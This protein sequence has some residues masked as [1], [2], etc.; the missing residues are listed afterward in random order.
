VRATRVVISRARSLHRMCVQYVVGWRGTTAPVG[1]LKSVVAGSV[2]HVGVGFS[3]GV[4]GK[5]YW[6]VRLINKSRY[7][8]L[9]GVYF[10]TP[11]VLSCIL[12]VLVLLLFPS[13]LTVAHNIEIIIIYIF[14][15]HQTIYLEI[16]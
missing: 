11:R 8:I 7:P 10:V 13:L 16:F 3:A 1:E 9:S 5:P 4:C 15:G 6:A 14:Y 2:Q 12:Y